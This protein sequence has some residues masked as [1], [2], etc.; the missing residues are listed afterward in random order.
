MEVDETLCSHLLRTNCPVTDQPDWASLY[1]SYKVKD[2]ARWTA[3]IYSLLPP[4][5]DFHEQCVEKIFADI[6]ARCQPTE[7][8]VYARYM[9]RGGLDINPFQYPSEGPPSYRQVRQ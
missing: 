8:S 1:V 4:A 2:R 3:Q 7:L 5:Q 9:R 6:M